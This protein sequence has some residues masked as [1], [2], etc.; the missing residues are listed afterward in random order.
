M[1]QIL[2]LGAGTAGTIMANRL[3]RLYAAEVR[4]KRT[5]ITVVDQDDEHVY[6]PGLLFIPFGGYSPDQVV[7]PRR[8]QL[9]PD[10]TYVRQSIARVETSENAVYLS[11][12]SRL[13][14]DVLIVASGARIVPTETEGL[15]GPGWR[16]KAFDFYTLDG[17]NALARTLADWPGGRLVVDIVE[18]PIKCP[19]APLEFAFLADAFFTKR[20]IREKVQ[21]TY[22][23]P[24]DSAF[25][26]PTCA[27]ALSHLL[28]EKGIELV[29]EFNAGRVDG[30]KGTLY[31]WDDREIP[32][33]LLVAIPVH[34]GA[35]FVSRSPGLGDDMGF[36]TTDPHTL[37]S[38]AAP[39]V[40]AIGDATNLP[41]SKAG[42]VAHFEAEILAENVRRFLA[43]EPLRPEFDGHANCFIE[44]GHD[45]AL[46]IDFNY[47]VEPL[48]GRFP[49]PGIGPMPLLEESRINHLGK[50]AF[51]WIY[52]NVLLPGH[53]IPGV[54]PQMSM[55]GKHQLSN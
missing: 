38:T 10:V 41:V 36:V 35:E 26:K 42:S 43:G 30:E 55:H 33:D 47:D 32:F 44:T 6:Q 50:R 52:W 27:R 49:I 9:H 28:T 53:D 14:Y 15:T 3:R 18:M 34:M 2:V 22:V 5:S 16:E 31:S 19:V 40:F 17:A 20:G 45:K 54:G 12:D 21:I 29:T 4:D 51:K 24:L 1:T 39:N 48:P 46:L 37:Q 8:E 11:D 7:R 25:T 13:P 23:T